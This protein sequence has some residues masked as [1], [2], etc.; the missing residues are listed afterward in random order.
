[1]NI[2]FLVFHG[3]SEANGISKKIHY[4][5]DAL[6]A[7]GH[8]VRLCYYI[9]DSQGYRMRMI[10]GE[11][12]ENYGKGFAAKIKKRCCYNPILQYSIAKNIQLVYI[13]SDHNANPFTIRLAKG[14][15]KNNIKIA[16][17]IPTYPYDMEYVSFPFS[18]RFQLFIDKSYRKKLAEQ[19]T[20]IVTF[21]DYE[22]IFGVK[23]I[24]ISNGIDFGQIKIKDEAK[25]SGNTLNLLGVA[26]VHYWHGFDRLIKGLGEYYGNPHNR[27]IIFH[28]IGGICDEDMR[29]FNNLIQKYQIEEYV[30]FHGQK[31]GTELD[32]FFNMADF[33]IGS[34][35]RHRVHINSIKTLKNREYAARGI[36]FIYS[37]TDSDF[38]TMPYIIKA[39][40]DETPVNIRQIDE[41]CSTHT[42]TPADI[43]NSIKSLSWKNQMQKVVN[44]IFN[45]S[46]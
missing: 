36:P 24:R 39:P 33:C 37:E 16:M 42:F 14:F 7:C 1:M 40:A 12:L 18:T 5:V 25:H 26:E 4:Q 6:K 9:V 44:A 27:K 31:Y 8:T 38:D 10:D 19:L 41:F 20:N 34:L 3:F 46:A 35:A 43:R 32:Y 23:T 11:V 21:S 30:V 28:V 17:E 22:T 2:L 13:R 45:T 15:R 29:Y